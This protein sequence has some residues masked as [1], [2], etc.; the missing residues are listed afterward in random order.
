MKKLF[1][2]LIVLTVVVVGIGFY[3]GWFTL[4]REDQAESHNVDVRLSVD[5]DK[6][7]QDTAAI[8]GGSQHEDA[9]NE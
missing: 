4:S 6:V 7:K 9:Q 2:I 3:R 5:T 1:Q 8:T